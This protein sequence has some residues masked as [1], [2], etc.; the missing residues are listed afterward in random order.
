MFIVLKALLPR[1]T[2]IK[3]VQSVRSMVAKAENPA[4]KFCSDESPVRVSVARDGFELESNVTRLGQGLTSRVVNWQELTKADV[5]DEHVLRSNAV[6]EV[7]SQS[8][9]V[10]DVHPARVSVVRDAI[11]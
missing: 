6:I 4:Y 3:P 9:T 7:V 5:N 11:E 10:K 2:F 1:S 8:K